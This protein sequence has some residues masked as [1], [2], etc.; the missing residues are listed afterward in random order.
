MAE[1]PTT[2]GGGGLLGKRQ[3]ARCPKCREYI[4]SSVRVCRFCK[5]ELSP[6]EMQAA[7]AQQ[8]VVTEEASRR[9]NKLATRAAIGS[10]ILSIVG[11]PILLAV[12]GIFVVHWG[13]SIKHLADLPAP[14]KLAAFRLTG[15]ND[16]QVGYVYNSFGFA[17]MNVWTWNGRYCLYKGKKFWVLSREG[18]R[19]FTPAETI[20]ATPFTY[21][22]PPGLIVL[23]SASVALM[24]LIGFARMKADDAAKAPYSEASS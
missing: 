20:P 14:A 7:A 4:D 8:A 3:L 2:L 21:R 6:E 11:F 19:V 23:V 22:Y 17:F 12:N 16:V 5:A 1:N 9:N 15:E 10:L 13:D 24:T 18:V